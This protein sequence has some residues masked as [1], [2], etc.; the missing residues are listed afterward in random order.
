MGTCW[1]STIPISSASGSVS[2]SASASGSPVTGRAGGVGM[3]VLPTGLPQSGPIVVHKGEPMADEA[4]YD[5]KG[6]V[7]LITP[8]RPARLNPW[9]GAMA[10]AYFD[11]LGAASPG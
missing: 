4:L 8:N 5:V 1:S 10:V 6:G 3:A 7:A 11:R 2:R 9:N